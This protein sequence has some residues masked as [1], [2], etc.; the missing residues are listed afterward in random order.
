MSGNSLAVAVNGSFVFHFSALQF[1]VVVS[2]LNL[3]IQNTGIMSRIH[4]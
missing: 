2:V 3:W 1:P 4:R